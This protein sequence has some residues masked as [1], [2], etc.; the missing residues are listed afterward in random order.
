MVT[1]EDFIHSPELEL[2]AKLIAPCEST[3]IWRDFIWM[4][5]P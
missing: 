5:L 4:V 1:P 3:A 2:D